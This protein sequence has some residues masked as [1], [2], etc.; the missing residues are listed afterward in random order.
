[1]TA[2]INGV[3]QFE[4]KLCKEQKSEKK[5]FSLLERKE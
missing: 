1:M 4:R 5:N 3:K 2:G